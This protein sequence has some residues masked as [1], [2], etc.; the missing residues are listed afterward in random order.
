MPGSSVFLEIAA[1]SLR[2]NADSL[3]SGPS[4]AENEARCHDVQ[5]RIFDLNG[6]QYHSPKGV[7]TPSRAR[8]SM[9]GT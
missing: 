8:A 2:R 5:G 1:R 7:C 9:T 3:L 6:G 4:F